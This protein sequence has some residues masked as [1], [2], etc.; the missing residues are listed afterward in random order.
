MNMIRSDALKAGGMTM[1]SSFGIPSGPEALLRLRPER[2]LA[3]RS[4]RNTYW[5]REGMEA[6]EARVV[7]TK[8]SNGE[9][10]WA[11]GGQGGAAATSG[12]GDHWS[13][14]YL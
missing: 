4:W 10:P 11:Q 12:D 13:E 14:K 3:N 8:G 6:G 1:S 2:T 9:G 7:R 5:S